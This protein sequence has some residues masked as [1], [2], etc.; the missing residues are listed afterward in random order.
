[1]EEVDLER[2]SVG[3]V[4]GE[5]VGLGE[6]LRGPSATESARGSAGANTSSPGW[7]TVRVHTPPTA[8]ELR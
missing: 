8:V 5:A 2:V 1:V 7:L 6:A 4:E 3:L